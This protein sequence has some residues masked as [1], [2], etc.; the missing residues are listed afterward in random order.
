MGGHIRKR[1][2]D[3]GLLQ[4][5]VAQ[6]LGVDKSTILNWERGH[7]SPA[8]RLLPRIIGLLSYSPL[9]PGDSVPE[10]LKHVSSCHGYCFT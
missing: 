9:V 5:E 3:L 1:R 6:Q 10:R 8:L 4:R 2:L 7:T